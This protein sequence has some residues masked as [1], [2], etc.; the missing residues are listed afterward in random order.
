MP[1]ALLTPSVAPLRL[2]TPS[3]LLPDARHVVLPGGIASSGAPAIIGTCRT[4]QIYLDPWQRDACTAILAKDASGWYAA[5]TVVLSIPRQVG[6]TFLIGAISFADSIANPGTLT[7]W[8]AHRFKVARESFDELRA[9]AESDAMAP[10]VDRDAITTAAGNEVIPFRNGSRIVFAARERGSIRGFRKVRRLVLDEA[11]ILTDA[12]LSDLAPTQNQAVNPQI[13]L[14]GTPPKPSDP[15]A[16]FTRLRSE[17]LSGE[18]EGVALV[19]YGAEPSSDL[20]DREAWRKANPS[21]PDR[22]PERAIQRLRRLLDDD[23]FLRE[24]LGIWSDQVAAH[25]AIDF[26]AWAA[27]AGP[28]PE[29]G[30]DV[31]F[32]LD[33]APDHSTAT[34][35]SAWTLPTDAKWLQVADHRPGVDWVVDR[36]DEL[37]S[38]WGGSLI[39]EQTGTAGF[40]LPRLENAEPVSRRFFVDA[41]STLDA[42]VSSA[43]LRHGNQ[44]ELNG[45][46]AAARWSASGDAGQRVLARKDPRV[47]PLV[48]A[49]LALHGLTTTTNVGGWVMAL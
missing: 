45:A 19:E 36:W 18:A 40:L 33:V 28:T 43:G 17:A 35:T 49:A 26:S 24:V 2:R 10:H 48:A 44:S 1:Q 22:T 9:L 41:C 21:Y 39:V 30:K 6:K 31:G 16:A 29:H 23:D 46:V 8:T 37:R 34:I 38:R 47:S 15:G 14:M 27:L 4:L 11:Q 3:G 7:V 20:D 13:I 32:A 12:A 5:D 42:A 25:A